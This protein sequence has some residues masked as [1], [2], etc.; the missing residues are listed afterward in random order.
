MVF[1]VIIGYPF[2]CKPDERA[3]LRFFV[4]KSLGV[5]IYYTIHPPA[6][7]ADA[8]LQKYLFDI[9]LSKNTRIAAYH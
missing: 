6:F 2:S 9:G 4:G 8:L 7:A 1:T 3:A 5:V